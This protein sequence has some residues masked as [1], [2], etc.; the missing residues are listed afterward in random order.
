MT[1]KVKHELDDILDD[2]EL[3]RRIQEYRKSPEW[4]EKSSGKTEVTMAPHEYLMS[5]P[6]DAIAGAVMGIG[7]KVISPLV[8]YGASKVIPKAA[9]LAEDAARSYYQKAPWT[10]KPDP[11]NYYRAGYGK[12]FLDDVV[13]TGKV[14]A[15]NKNSFVNKQKAGEISGIRDVNTGKI[16]LKAKAFLRGVHVLFVIGVQ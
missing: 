3:L 2:N 12:E 4:Y 5:L 11:N 6:E 10:W 15:Y 9:K 1:K 16:S 7:S 14:R 13:N 8:K